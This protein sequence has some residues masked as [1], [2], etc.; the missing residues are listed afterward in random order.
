[1]TVNLPD[2]LHEKARRIT[3]KRSEG[4]NAKAPLTTTV[5]QACQTEPYVEKCRWMTREYPEY[6]ESP[7]KK[8]WPGVCG[9]AWALLNA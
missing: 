8:S 5:L 1:M 3:V 9:L 6:K 2:D 7:L 4:K